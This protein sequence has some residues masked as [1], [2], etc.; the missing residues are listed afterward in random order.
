[1]STATAEARAR[2]AAR[3]LDFTEAW[4]FATNAK[5]SGR[6]GLIPSC[7][8]SGRPSANCIGTKRKSPRR[9]RLL[10]KP[11]R[12]SIQRRIGRRAADLH[13]KILHDL[14]LQVTALRSFDVRQLSRLVKYRFLGPRSGTV[15]RIFRSGRSEPSSF[16]CP[17]VPSAQSRCP[18][19]HRRSLRAGRLNPCRWAS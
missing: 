15:P 16:L 17:P 12:A 13:D 1:M 18:P 6:S 5:E 7:S 4:P 11:S 2:C 3:A 14:S 9:S 8:A 19:S 10:T